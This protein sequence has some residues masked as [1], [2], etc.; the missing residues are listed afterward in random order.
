MGRVN[1][2]IS[3]SRAL[4]DWCIKKLVISTPD[5]TRRERDRK[6]EF[7]ILACDGVWDVLN[8]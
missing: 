6:D 1:G 7:I 8:D 5:V 3:V 2:F 4:G